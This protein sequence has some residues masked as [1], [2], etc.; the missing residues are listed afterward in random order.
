MKRILFLILL[1]ISCFSQSFDDVKSRY[2]LDS[3]FSILLDSNMHSYCLINQITSFGNT[4]NGISANYWNDYGNQP[5]EILP[6]RDSNSIHLNP[7]LGSTKSGSCFFTIIGTNGNSQESISIN[8]Y[9][10]PTKISSNAYDASEKYGWKFRYWYL[11]DIK[12][13]TLK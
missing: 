8:N 5:Y 2:E 9:D 13:L 12:K 11:A 10:P 6:S 4:Y 7:L 1:P 3:N